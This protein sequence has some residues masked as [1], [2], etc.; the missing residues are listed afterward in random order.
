MHCYARQW[1]ALFAAALTLAAC[2]TTSAGPSRAGADTSAL[3]RDIAHLASDAL[4]GRGTGT[5]GND[6]AAA[7]IADRFAALELEPADERTCAEDKCPNMYF[8]PFTARSVAAAHAGLSTALPTQNV[9]GIL[10]G[11]DPELRDEYVVLGAHFDHLGRSS[12]GALDP[13]SARAIRNG[14]DDNA[15]GTAAVLELARLLGQRPPDRSIIF[16]AFSG[17]E[18]GLLGS[19][20]FVEH[21][22][23]PLDDIVA[24]LNFDMVGRMRDA[25]LIV[26]GVATARELPSLLDSANTLRTLDLR[27]IGDGYGP[28]DHSS[29][30]G[31]GIPVLHFFTDLHEDYH[32]A[33]DDSEK[34]NVS[35]AAQV[36]DFAEEVTR[37]IADRPDGLTAVRVQAPIIAS[38][39]RG[40]GT[41]LG[42]IP[43]MSATELRG[44]RL[45]GVRPDSPADRA[46]LREGDIIVEFGGRTVADLYEY[47]DALRAHKP[48]DVVQIIAVRDGQRVEL[49][50]TLGSRSN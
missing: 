42:T 37:A 39:G 17:E 3:H 32:R 29:F 27:L 30:Y 47:T 9:I 8:Q 31:K 20:Y 5:A 18:L 26:Y 2:R 21:P 11:S 12:L 10:R 23:V 28:S 14:A 15:S 24:M 41:Y 48:G 22:P 33:S 19:Q 1:S 4:E 43:D 45:I 13:D 6:S 40:Y 50:A 7:F 49:S 25:K 16:A 35:G 34:V 46:G 44:V 36:V 38:T